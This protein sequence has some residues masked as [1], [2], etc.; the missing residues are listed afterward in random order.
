MKVTLDI[1]IIEN[2]NSHILS[3]ADVSDY[4][5][6]MKIENATLEIT[7]PGFERKFL[8]FAPRQIN[9]YNSAT[10]GLTA[11]D[12]CNSPLPDGLWHIK[13]SVR[14]N[15]ERYT[16]RTFMRIFLL[17]EKFDRAFLKLDLLCSFCDND[18]KLRKLLG[19]IQLYIQGAVA[20]A[21]NCNEKLAL[22]FYLRAEKM[23]KNIDCNI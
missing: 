2:Y 1:D 19:D 11:P 18:G 8:S 7:V 12:V 10:L 20:A 15:Y 16:E 14:P 9:V 3:V 4:P 5:V 21:E 6:G 13:Y 23:L 17:Q 22:S